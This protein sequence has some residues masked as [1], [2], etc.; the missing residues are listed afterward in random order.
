MRPQAFGG[1]G[2]RHRAVLGLLAL[3]LGGCSSGAKTLTVP[4]SNFPGYEYFYLA[5][6]KGL[7]RPFG[8]DLR[9]VEFVDP[10]AI[11][12]AYLRGDLAMA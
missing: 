4:I 3:L 9:T 8:V 10:Q 6:Q 7:A 12:H 5:E 11:V 1:A 2:R